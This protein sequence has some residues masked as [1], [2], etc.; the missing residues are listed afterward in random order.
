MH[1]I[2]TGVLPA[3]LA[4][5]LAGLQQLRE[6]ADYEREVEIDADQT[7]GARQDADRIRQTIGSWLREK[8]WLRASP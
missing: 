5:L 1:F 7:R 8:D 3:D 2:R 6:D 4:R